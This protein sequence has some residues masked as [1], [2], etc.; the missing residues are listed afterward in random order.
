MDDR[1]YITG[2]LKMEKG[3]ATSVLRNGHTPDAD[4]GIVAGREE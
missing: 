1:K 2:V 3:L 4:S